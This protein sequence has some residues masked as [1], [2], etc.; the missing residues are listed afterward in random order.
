MDGATL[1]DADL[2]QASLKAADLSRAKGLTR[3]QG[4]AA[5]GAGS[6]Q[7]PEGIER[8]AHWRP[9]KLN[10]EAYHGRFRSWITSRRKPWSH[11]SVVDYWAR[12][13]PIGFRNVA[14]PGEVVGAPEDDGGAG[15]N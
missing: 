12:V 13:E 3:S 4:D 5:F 2:S 9:E 10:D 1:E 6:V 11:S 7:L 15:S 14:A 8:P